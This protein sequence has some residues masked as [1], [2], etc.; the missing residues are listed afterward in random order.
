MLIKS[1]TVTLD[2]GT[3]AEDFSDHVY[4]AAIDS[5]QSAVDDRTFGKPHATAALT[6]AESV[7]LTCR[8]SDAF[9]ALLTGHENTDLDLVITPETSA[10]TITATVQFDKVPFPSVQI[11]EQAECE[12]VLA[13]VDE[14]AYT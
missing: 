13:V 11:G 10:D 2:M 1:P 5:P 12:L 3:G 9:I 7:T 14:L 4:M 8:Y 6:G